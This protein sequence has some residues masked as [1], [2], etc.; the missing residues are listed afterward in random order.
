MDQRPRK[1]QWERML[2]HEMEEAMAACP[3]ALVPLGT[4]EWHGLQNCLG[5]D[6]LKAHELCRQA[7]L[8]GGGVVLP[9]LYGGMG[10]VPEP[11]TVCI[12]DEEGTVS[13]ILGNWLMALCM[14]LGRVGFKAAIIVTGHYGATQQLIVREAAT[15]ATQRLAIPVLGTPEYFLA[16][17]AGYT[18]DH[19]GVFETSLMMH[20]HPELVDL[21]R[22]T[23]DPPYQ[24]I[25][26]GDAKRESSAE[27]GK[28]LSDVMVARLATLATHMPSWDEATRT[29]FLRA[30]QALLNYQM[31]AAGKARN[32]W[33]AWADV[34]RFAP[35][36]RLLAEQRF[37]E[38][39]A[40]VEGLS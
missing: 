5:V 18:G 22:L 25:G 21:A 23:G 31:E 10:G 34:N 9:P 19:G 26:G 7:A 11:F 15:R 36:G 17:D 6:A 29:A 37:A 4:L 14:E 3:T 38:I 35:Y 30:E 1:V 20:L 13:R 40:L 12:E 27:Y 32:T 16:I 8:A 28:E 24:G 2:P 39:E 33:A